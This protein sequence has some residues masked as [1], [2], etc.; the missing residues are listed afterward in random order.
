MNAAV[1]G[2]RSLFLAALVLTPSWALSNDLAVVVGSNT[3]LDADVEPLRYGDDDAIRTAS[4][5]GQARS[6]V[7]VEPDEETRRLVGPEDYIRHER[8]SPGCA[9][10][11]GDGRS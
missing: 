7:L 5:F 3:A 8:C 11:D 4:L 2:L 6:T 1:W 9:G 10:Q